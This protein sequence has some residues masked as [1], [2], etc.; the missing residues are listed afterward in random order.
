MK[1]IIGLLLYNFLGIYLPESTYPILGKSSKCFRRFCTNLI[2][3]KCGKNINIERGA[4]FSRRIEIGDNSGI[5]INARINGKVIIGN[6]VMM[7]PNCVI[8]TVNHCHDRTDIPMILQG[9]EIERLVIIG[10]D[11]W[12]GANVIILPGVKIGNGVII[13]AGS[14]VTKSVDD[15]K[16]IAGNP[17]IIIRNRF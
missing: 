5:G 17:A 3:K 13:A 11:V 16:V 2:L 15:Y 14:V 1:Q 12:I 9:N 10:S 6:N 4:K 7:G 8:Y